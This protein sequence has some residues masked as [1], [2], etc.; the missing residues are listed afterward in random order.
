MVTAVRVPALDGQ[1]FGTYLKL[2]RK[3]GD[4]ATVGVAVHLAFADGRV[5][6]AGIALT[7]VAPTT[8]AATEAAASLVG[9]E[10]TDEAIAQAAGLAAQAAQPRSDQRGSADYKRRVVQV[11]TERGLRSAAEGGVAA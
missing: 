8:I 11:F 3:V 7:A 2:E 10:L 4:F 6:Q 1:T 5:R 9:A